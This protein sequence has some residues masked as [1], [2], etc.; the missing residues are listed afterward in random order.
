EENQSAIFTHVT[1]SIRER[2]ALKDQDISDIAADILQY[3]DVRTFQLDRQRFDV[4]VSMKPTR[5]SSD[6][7]QYIQDCLL[8]NSTLSNYFRNMFAS[9]SLLPQDKREMIIFKQNFELIKEAIEKDR[10]I[11]FTTVKSEKPHIVSPYSV[12]NS[13]EELFNY[14]LCKYNDLPY[15]FRVSRIKQIKVLNETRDLTEK[16]IEILDRMARFGPQF[17]YEIKKPYCPIKVKLTDR[18]LKQYRSMYLHRPEYF[19]N[20]GDIYYFDCS[21]SQA[22]QYFSRLGSNAIVLEPRE[23]VADL[24]RFYAIANRKYTQLDRKISQEKEE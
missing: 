11:Y 14:L 3:V 20:E 13:K 24:H 17:S 22:F 5:K 6:D 21:R 18:G 12:A 8:G 16:I 19:K 9:Y 2:T 4:A 10:K 15:S 1:D 23:L 7:I